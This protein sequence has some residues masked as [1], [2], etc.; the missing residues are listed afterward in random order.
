MFRRR[1]PCLVSFDTSGGSLAEPA[2]ANRPWRPFSRA[3]SASTSIRVIAPSTTGSTAARHSVIRTSRRCVTAGRVT[4]GATDRPRT[5]SKRWQAALARPWSSS[6]RTSA[7]DP[8]IGSS[9]WTTSACCHA[10]W[11]RCSRAPRRPRFS[12]RRRRFAGPR[13]VAAMQMPNEHE[14]TGATSIPPRSSR[15]DYDGTP[16]GMRRSP[17]KPSLWVSRFSPSTATAH[18][19]TSPTNSP[20][21]FG[22]TSQD[23]AEFPDRPFRGPA[24]AA[25]S[26]SN[27]LPSMSCITMQDSLSSSAGSSRTR[28]APSATSRAHSA[29]SVASR[30][31]PTSPMPARTSR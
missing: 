13:S 17:A 16:S 25:Q 21:S 3:G 22:C 4:R 14:P 27:S 30:S 7:P 29:S 6:S 24:T 20:D 1:R 2:L 19:R 11:L 18:P 9:S 5:S 28:V 10:I 12:F 31:S 15:P 23:H 8:P 26:R